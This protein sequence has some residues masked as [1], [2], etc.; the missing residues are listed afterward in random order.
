MM[1]SKN[2]DEVIK[3][4][5]ENNIEAIIFGAESDLPIL[6]LNSVIFGAKYK[7]SSEKFISLLKEK[8]IKS[9]ASFFG[10]S[11]SKIVTAALD[12]LGVEKYSGNDISIIRLVNS[13]F[14][15]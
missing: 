14:N 8:L 10:M 6:N 7:V 3:L 11:L 1:K 4:M 15:L 12:V 5:E 2:T 9:E 13:N